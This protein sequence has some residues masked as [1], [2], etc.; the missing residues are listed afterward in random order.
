MTGRNKNLDL[1][2]CTLCEIIKAVRISI[3]HQELQICTDC[4]TDILHI[5]EGMLSIKERGM[6]GRK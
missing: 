1:M 6:P 4:L 2:P 5:A 3:W